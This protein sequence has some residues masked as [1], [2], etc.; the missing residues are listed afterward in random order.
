MAETNELLVELKITR[1]L[2]E[3]ALGVIRQTKGLVW[4]GE[5]TAA[6]Q[7]ATVDALLAA[8]VPA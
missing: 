7:I 1:D 8:Q 5:E 4:M 2:L 3:I 6:K